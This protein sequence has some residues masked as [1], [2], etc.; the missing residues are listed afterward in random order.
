V[1]PRFVVQPSTAG[2]AHMCE[3]RAR[4]RHRGGADMAL[5]KRCPKYKLHHE[6]NSFWRYIRVRAGVDRKRQCRRF[7]FHPAVGAQKRG[8]SLPVFAC[9]VSG[10]LPVLLHR[11]LSVQFLRLRHMHDMLVSVNFLFG[12]RSGRGLSRNGR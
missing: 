1:S 5:R 9:K 10:D 8:L 6:M 2:I 12:R 11:G 3:P 7:A 4:L